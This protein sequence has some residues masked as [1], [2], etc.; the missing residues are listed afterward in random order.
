VPATYGEAFG[1]YVIEA[2]ASGVPVRAATIMVRFPS[3]SR[4]RS[5]G[6]LCRPDDPKALAD[7]LESL[8]QDDV[9]REKMA[10]VATAR[11]RQEFT[12]TRMAERFEALLL[13][14]TA[15]AA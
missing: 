4:P 11:V 1:L 2:A 15:R 10:R 9:A 7:A 3:S 12:S 8:L 14:A 13:G 5:G 6:I